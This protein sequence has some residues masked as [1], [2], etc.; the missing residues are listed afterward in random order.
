MRESVFPVRLGNELN[1]TLLCIPVRAEH[2]FPDLTKQGGEGLTTSSMFGPF[3]RKVAPHGFFQH[4]F[5]FA[6]LVFMKKS[7]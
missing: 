5:H 7:G 3:I 4:G 6:G 2:F 1:L